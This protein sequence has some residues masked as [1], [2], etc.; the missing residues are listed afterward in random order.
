[1]GRLSAAL[2]L[3]A[4]GLTWA[5]G[6]AGKRFG[7]DPALDRYS[8]KTPQD[9]LK[10]IVSAIDNKKVDYLIAHLADPAWVDRQIKEYSAGIAKGG[11][12][13]KAFIAFD[14][15]VK[16]TN[17]YFLSDPSILKE[18]RQFAKEAAWEMMDNTAVGTVKGIEGRKVY[19]RKQD[20]R[21]YLE[22]KQN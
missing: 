2:C 10:S 16:E 14:R 6:D 7:L 1:M 3:F 13:A 5:Q 15:L 12:E 4:A 8:Q 19:L 20:M 11:D 17:E 22:N 9:T 21:W 18:L